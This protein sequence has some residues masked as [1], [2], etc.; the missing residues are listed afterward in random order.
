VR[1]E[2]RQ[3]TARRFED[4]VLVLR[5][6]PDRFDQRLPRSS[7]PGSPRAC[8]PSSRSPPASSSRHEHPPDVADLR[9][10]PPTPSPDD[11]YLPSSGDQ[12]SSSVVIPVGQRHRVVQRLTEGPR[13]A[14]GGFTFVF[15]SLCSRLT[16]QMQPTRPGVGSQEPGVLQQLPQREPRAAAGRAGAVGGDVTGAAGGAVSDWVFASRWGAEPR[17]HLGRSR[18]R[19]GDRELVRCVRGAAGTRLGLCAIS[20]RLSEQRSWEALGFVRASDYCDERPGVSTRSLQEM[21]RVHRVLAGAPDLE[22][23][24]LAGRLGWTRLRELARDSATGPAGT[25]VDGGEGESV[26]EDMDSVPIRCAAAV[27]AK[28]VF[29]CELTR[30]VV[31]GRMST[32]DCAEVIAAEVSSCLALD[33]AGLS[34][35]QEPVE[36]GAALAEVIPEHRAG[37]HQPPSPSDPELEPDEDDPGRSLQREIAGLLEGLESASPSELDRRLRR[38]LQLERTQWLGRTR[39]RFA[40]RPDNFTLCETGT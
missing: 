9:R 19:G 39:P 10:W 29:G 25:P 12:S 15:C 23:A 8:A 31:G 5:D 33:P 26:G 27:R 30:R 40:I 16:P 37:A 28:W 34:D 1:R 4:Q 38:A 18:A 32:A 21:A 14:K 7:R 17:R 3:G 24:F 35:L 22:A 36:G 6:H 2:G 11:V 20:A 13:Q